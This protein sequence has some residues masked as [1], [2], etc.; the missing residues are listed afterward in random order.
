MSVALGLLAVLAFSYVMGMNDGAALV[1]LNVSNRAI[2]S[3]ASALLLSVVVPLAPVVLGLAVAQTVAFRL[4]GVG[5]SAGA[6]IVLAGMGVAVALVII[7]SRRGLPTSLTLALIGGII[8]AGVGGGLKISTRPVIGVLGSALAAPVVAVV[9]A[10][11][12]RRLLDSASVIALRSRG[13]RTLHVFAFMSQSIAYGANDGQKA[14]AVALIIVG[15]IRPVGQPDLPAWALLTV[16][17]AFLA[18]TLT[19][20]RAARRGLGS[21]LAPERTHHSIVAQLASAISVGVSAAAGMPV[22]MTQASTAGIVGSTAAESSRRVR[23]DQAVRLINAWILTL[24]SSVALGILA[25]VIVRE[26][27]Q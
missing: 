25:G 3:L 16:G 4:V 7:L 10:G 2:G 20:L 21:R 17:A 1:T 27:S 26:L 9:I 22:S 15:L 11:T 12:F 14:F 6:K 13:L 19:G 8:G 18:G 23:W 24:P 5:G